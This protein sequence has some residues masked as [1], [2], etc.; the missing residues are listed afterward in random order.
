MNGSRGSLSRAFPELSLPIYLLICF[1]LDHRSRYRS[2]TEHQYWNVDIVLIGIKEK[3]IYHEWTEVYMMKPWQKWER[4]PAN[5]CFRWYRRHKCDI[6]YI[7]YSDNDTAQTYLI[8][9]GLRTTQTL[10][11]VML[12]DESIT[13]LSWLYIIYTFCIYTK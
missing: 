13:L 7:N 5:H 6:D 9:F 4:S 10:N 1:W 2:G 8:Y 11:N 3:K 12:F